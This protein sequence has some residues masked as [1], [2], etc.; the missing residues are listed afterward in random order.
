MKRLLIATMLLALS[1]CGG[2]APPTTAGAISTAGAT[3]AD[4]VGV[5]APVTVADK[6]T[7]DESLGRG[8]NLAYKAARTACEIAVD[9]GVIKGATAT[10][11]R[12]LNRQAYAAVQAVDRAYATGNARSYRE[13]V[14]QAQALAGQLLTLTGKAN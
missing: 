9:A 7:L 3:A 8:A 10:R 11:F 4:A 14:D 13:A 2:L 1:A 6:T 5:P 12:V